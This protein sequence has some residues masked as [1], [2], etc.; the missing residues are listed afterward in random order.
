MRPL[1][2]FLSAILNRLRTLFYF[3]FFEI[4]NKKEGAG[5]SRRVGAV[6]E[7]RTIIFT[8]PYI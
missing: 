6:P 8:Q 4:G 1:F 2:I 3:L 5:G 7:K